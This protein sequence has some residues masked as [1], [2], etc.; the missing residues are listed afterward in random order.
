MTKTLIIILLGLTCCT[1]DKKQALKSLDNEVISSPDNEF[2][3]FIS[4]LPKLNLPFET[5]CDKCCD[6][7]AIDYDHEL[8][9]KFRPQGSAIVGLVTKTKDKVVILVTYPADIRLPSI[10][11]YD[12][13]G[14][15]TGEM[16]FLTNYCGGDFEYYGTQF[17]RINPD[18]SFC[19]IDTSYYLKMDTIDYH[20]IDTIKI[21][22]TR[23]QFSINS[24]GEVIEDNAR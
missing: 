2:L 1:V 3:K 22:I 24:K 8:I 6:H 17:F 4:L 23:K 12:L 18:I 9:N 20:V 15:L 11:V 10:R 21:E 13:N 14:N 5:N 16:N 19:S 7:P